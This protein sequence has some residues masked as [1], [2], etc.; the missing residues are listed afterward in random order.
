MIAGM[1][2]LDLE[3]S[4]RLLDQVVQALFAK[5]HSPV[6]GA[7]VKAQVI[8]EANQQGYSFSEREL[9]FKNFVDF[10]RAT[11]GISLQIR[12][13]S[14]MLLAPSS[15]TETLSAYA[16]PL[17]RLRRDFWRAFIEFPVPNTVRLYDET[18]D[19]ILYEDAAT[20]R[21]GVLIEPVSRD[22]QLQWRRQFAEEQPDSVK[23]ALLSALNGTG[24]SS[25]NDFARRL[26]ENP[27]ITRAWNRY[28]QKL[29]TDCVSAWAAA[30]NIPPERWSGGASRTRIDGSLTEA[31]S[32]PQNISQRAELYNFFDSLPIEDLLELR[33]PLDWV[34]KVA[35]EKR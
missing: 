30:R 7:L 23:D 24:S 29:V 6:P 22:T 5:R 25:F 4:R 9:G 16:H 15:A 28:L 12:I 2:T 20:E 10:V 1:Q 13:G 8:R 14:D 34:L 33:V 31:I 17:P 26:R 35:R 3:R 27:P 18:E 21:K 32:K 11:P 19:K